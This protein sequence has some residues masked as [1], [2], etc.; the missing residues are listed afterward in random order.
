MKMG[1]VNMNHILETSQR[2]RNLLQKLSE[3]NA[4]YESE[5]AALAAK[6]QDIQERVQQLA[7]SPANQAS[8]AKLQRDVQMTELTLRQLQERAQNDMNLTSERYRQRVFSEVAT[9]V[10]SYAKQQGLDLVMY[11]PNPQI[12]YVG[13]NADITAAVLERYDMTFGNR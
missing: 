5:G 11:G 8:M 4:K 3:L 6:I 12:A 1:I 7:A 9:V 13:P 2:G 10:E